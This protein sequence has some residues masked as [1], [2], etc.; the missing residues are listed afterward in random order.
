[1]DQIP[2]RDQPP[3]R[4]AKTTAKA[5]PKPWDLKQYTYEEQKDDQRLPHRDPRL[6]LELQ[7]YDQHQEQFDSDFIP[8][9]ADHGYGL[10]VSGSGFTPEL[11]ACTSTA[12]DQGTLAGGGCCAK[13]QADNTELQRMRQQG[14]DQIM[15]II[16]QTLRQHK[17][18]MKQLNQ[19]RQNYRAQRGAR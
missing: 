16:Q 3:E 2:H 14:Q 17:D 19:R 8:S 6:E 4:T 7:S 11:Y 10:S 12:S 5:G 13:P 18:T 15:Q 1:M 9:D